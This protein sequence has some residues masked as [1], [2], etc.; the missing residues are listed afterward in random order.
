M[1]LGERLQEKR[2]QANL[3]QQELAQ[4]LNVSRQTISN[5]EVGRSYPDIE[6]LVLLSELFSISLDVL[7]KGDVKVITSLKK[8]SVLSSLFL[9]FI[10]G[11]V[12]ADAICLVV[13][14]SLTGKPS[15]SLI[16]LCASV[17]AGSSFAIACYSGKERLLKTM[18]GV[19]FLVWPLLLTIQYAL[20]TSES[21]FWNDGLIITLISLA[22]SWLM[23]SLWRY[24]RISIWLLSILTM[25]ISLGLNY[26]TMEP[27]GG[28]LITMEFIVFNLSQITLVLICL[29]IFIFKLDKGTVDAWLFRKIRNYAK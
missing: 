8:R 10:G 29:I 20:P 2:K 7:L 23:I 6:S 16:V 24:T 22:G 28:S 26:Y 27:I 19:T 14:F 17:C 1:N 25:I 9:I 13:D 21:W 11:L 3:T 5:W 15:W 18:L 4:Q 12:L